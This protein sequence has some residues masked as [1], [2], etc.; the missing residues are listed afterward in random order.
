VALVETWHDDSLSPD[1]IACAPPAFKFV[2]KARTRKK[3]QSMSTNH[4]GVCLMYDVSL[5]ARPLQLPTFSTFEVVA[6]YV[7]RAGFNAVVVV[8]YRPGSLHVTNAFFD[9]FNDLLERLAIYSAPLMIVGD[10]NIHMHDAS[11]AYA[12]KLSDILASHS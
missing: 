5:H 4:G 7:H 2:E 10:F 1:L 8:L 9:N 6:T 11:D 12:G 3:E